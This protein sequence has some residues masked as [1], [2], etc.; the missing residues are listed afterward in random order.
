MVTR[1]VNHPSILM[2]DSGNEGGFNRDLDGEF[3]FY[4][5]QN[6]LVMHPWEVF[7][8][9]DT[10]HYPSY[11]ILAKLL[12]GPNLVMPTELLHGIYDG[13]AGAALEDFWKL[14]D[15]SPYGAGGFIWVF[16]DEGV[17]R[18]DQNG[19]IDVFSTFAPD[20]IVGPHHEKEGSFYTIRDVFSPVQL[21]APILDEH[22]TGSLTVQNRFDF[23]SLAECRFA[24]KLLRYPGPMAETPLP[25]FC[26]KARP[27]PLRFRRMATVR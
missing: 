11:D 2:W 14:M 10:K 23:V 3:A 22:F 26:P 13:G 8:G 18:T 24:W 1:D 27:P 7:N 4:D 5:P 25:S 6:R 15:R 16:A 21:A 20:G 12:G 17:Q 9:I 19:R